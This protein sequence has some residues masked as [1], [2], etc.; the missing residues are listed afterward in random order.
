LP[1]IISSPLTNGG[2]VE[3]LLRILYARKM[4]LGW[5]IADI[6]EISLSLYIHKILMEESDKRTVQPQ[7]HLKSI[8]QEVVRKKNLR[9]LNAGMISHISD[10]SWVSPI[11]VVPNKGGLTVVNNDNNELFLFRTTMGW[12]VCMDYRKL[13]KA[14]RKDHFPLNFIDQMLERLGDM[15]IIIF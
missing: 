6:E 10:S 8:M 9:L 5:T 15:L 4:A 14:T 11:Q 7:C 1:L 2:E 13:N 12:T 3:K